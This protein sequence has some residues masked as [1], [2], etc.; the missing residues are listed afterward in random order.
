MLKEPIINL[1]EE[2]T[3]TKTIIVEIRE[4][5][6]EREEYKENEIVFL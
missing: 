4:E 2:T 6:L 5:G 1:E 3:L